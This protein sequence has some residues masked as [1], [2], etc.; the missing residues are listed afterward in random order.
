MTYITLNMT[1][2]QRTHAHI[3]VHTPLHSRAQDAGPVCGCMSSVLIA[4]DISRIEFG[5]NVDVLH[6]PITQSVLSGLLGSKGRVTSYFLTTCEAEA[7]R[8]SWSERKRVSQESGV[9]S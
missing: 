1:A 9:P 6:K 4:P 7:L 3:T 5:V 8:E 2:H